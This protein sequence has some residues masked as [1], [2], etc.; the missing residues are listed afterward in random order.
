MLYALA[1][2]KKSL[3]YK[4]RKLKPH[5]SI[6]AIDKD[7]TDH[8]HTTAIIM[9]PMVRA[10]I[11]AQTLEEMDPFFL[12]ANARVKMIKTKMSLI[13]IFKLS[14]NGHFKGSELCRG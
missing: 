1:R 14:G 6:R 3:I 12:L 5:C 8:H 13:V 11:Q 9:L 4:K 2:C 10:A 7:E